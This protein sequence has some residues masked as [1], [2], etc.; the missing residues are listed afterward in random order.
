[1]AKR[2]VP[3]V[4]YKIP[5][6]DARGLIQPTWGKWFRELYLR[7]GGTIAF[8]NAELEEELFADVDSLEARMDAVEAI[9]TTQTTNISTNTTNIATNTSAIAAL[10]DLVDG[11]LK[12][13]VPE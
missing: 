3:E 1:M 10:S 9:N 5:M 2:A 13:P 6:T 8:S 12:A 7:V 4:P 11:L